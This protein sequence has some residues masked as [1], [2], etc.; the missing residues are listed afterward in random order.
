MASRD[1]STEDLGPRRPIHNPRMKT[2]ASRN[3]QEAHRI[4]V[5]QQVY[6]VLTSLVAAMA[7]SVGGPMAAIDLI[8]KEV[9]VLRGDLETAQKKAARRTRKGGK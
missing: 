3:A 5:R 7:S 1:D 6:R 4:R 8:G 9:E 2:E